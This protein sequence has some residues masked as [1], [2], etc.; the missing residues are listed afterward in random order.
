MRISACP[1]RLPISILATTPFIV[2]TLTAC[3]AT[4]DATPTADPTP[5]TPPIVMPD[6]VGL[7][8]IDAW[9][10]LDDAG[11]DWIEDHGENDV[12]RDLSV[13]HRDVETYDWTIHTTIPR[14]GT[15]LEPGDTVIGFA[16]ETRE[17]EFF[18][19][20]PVMPKT[21][22]KV[23]E[24][25]SGYWGDEMADIVSL[26]DKRYIHSRTP[27]DA[28]RTT[29]WPEP[30]SGLPR[31]QDPSVEPRWERRVRAR[32]AEA[33]GFDL[34]VGTIPAVGEPLRPGQA[35]VVLYRPTRK[36][37]PEVYPEIEQETPPPFVPIPDGDDD[38]DDFNFP[39]WLC[40]TRFC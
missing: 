40:P 3:V 24:R 9:G 4:S 33:P 14:A 23:D 37:Q 32:L 16:L 10:A 18:E 5:T 36:S 35:I 30:D 11:I 34:F 27:A 21:G 19:R 8:A 29:T 31:A 38:D 15:S 26:S 20:N 7:G 22:W 13:L 28:D 25:I 2:A 12:F 17:Y 39:G 1:T 6:I